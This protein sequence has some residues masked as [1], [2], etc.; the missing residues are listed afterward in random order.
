MTE[1]RTISITVHRDS[2]GKPT[3][4]TNIETATCPYLLFST[5]GQQPVCAMGINTDVFDSS[6]K[7]VTGLIRPHKNC[8]LWQGEEQ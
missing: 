8:P 2:D 6:G 3:C 7:G 5:F 1:T 4:C